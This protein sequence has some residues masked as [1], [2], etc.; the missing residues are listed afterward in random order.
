[1]RV[2]SLF[3]LSTAWCE[4]A[5]VKRMSVLFLCMFLLLSWWDFFSWACQAK[6]KS[7]QTLPLQWSNFMHWRQQTAQQPCQTLSLLPPRLP[8]GAHGC[9]TMW[10]QCCPLLWG[11]SCGRCFFPLNPIQSVLDISIRFNVFLLNLFLSFQSVRWN[12]SHYLFE[13]LAVTAFPF[14]FFLLYK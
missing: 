6:W 7:L 14:S 2:S 11:Y 8:A 1:M 5:S 13:L 9:V 10:K 3:S 4:L 12:F